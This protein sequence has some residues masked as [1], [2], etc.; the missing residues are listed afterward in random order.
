MRATDW[1]KIFQS[2]CPT[3]GTSLRIYKDSQTQLHEKKIQF[4]NGQNDMNRYSQKDIQMANKYVKNFPN[5]LA[6]IQ[7]MKTKT[8]DI[9]IRKFKMKIVT[10]PNV[11]GFKKIS[12]SYVA[13]C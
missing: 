5:I 12:H 7:E 6:I 8:S 3:K 2:T 1:E 10:A 11:S 4:E 13:C 9:P